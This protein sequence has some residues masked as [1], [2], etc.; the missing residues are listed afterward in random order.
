MRL[1]GKGY[2]PMTSSRYKEAQLKVTEVLPKK[3][4]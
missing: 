2:D 3:Q 1:N 4:T